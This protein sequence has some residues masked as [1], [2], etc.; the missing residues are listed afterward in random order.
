MTDLTD[1]RKSLE[2]K[3]YQIWT[4]WAQPLCTNIA[5]ISRLGDPVAY[6]YHTNA[7]TALLAAIA[8]AEAIEGAGS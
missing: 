3:G 1:R 5:S 2:A 7:Q 4:S 6:T 8:A